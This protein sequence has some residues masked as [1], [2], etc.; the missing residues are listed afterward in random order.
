MYWDPANQVALWQGGKERDTGHR[1][2]AKGSNSCG[3]VKTS[4]G[5]KSQAGV[6]DLSNLTVYLDWLAGVSVTRS[7]DLTQKVCT[8]ECP[9]Q[10]VHS[11]SHLA[12]AERTRLH[13]RSQNQRPKQM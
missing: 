13:H 1:C 3:Q 11:F 2:S 7:R 10:R 12:L 9:Q 6:S 5:R 4:G 8:A